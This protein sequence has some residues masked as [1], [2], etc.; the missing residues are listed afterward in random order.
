MGGFSKALPFIQLDVCI[1]TTGS[2]SA[3]RR[4]PVCGE[5]HRWGLA[6][7]FDAG[8]ILYVAK[9]RAYG[10]VG[11][12]AP[13]RGQRVRSP[14][15]PRSKP[16]GPASA[17]FRRTASGV[18]HVERLRRRELSCSYEMCGART[19]RTDIKQEDERRTDTRLSGQHAG[20]RY[21]KKPGLVLEV[22]PD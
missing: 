14:A 16:L 2:G 12:V 19:S 22:R 15:R 7:A 20:R 13:A 9:V 17:L 4:G 18:T 3:G 10:R 11:G 21:I 6:D 8:D 1:E 5:G